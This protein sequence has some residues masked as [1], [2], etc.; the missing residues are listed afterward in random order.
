M[1]ELVFLAL[2]IILIALVFD[3]INGFHDSANSIATVVTTGVLAP[4]GAVTL[5]TLMN[6]VGVYLFGTAIASTVGKGIVN[7]GFVTLEV[8]LA[9]L[10]GAIAWNLLTWYKGIPSSSSHALIGGLIGA[11]VAAGGASALLWNGIWTVVAFILV[12]PLVGLA[13]SLAFGILVLQVVKNMQPHKINFWFRKLQL[14]SSSSYSL[15]HGTNDAQKTMG[16]IALV[17]FSQHAID[18]FYIPFWVIMAAYSAIA[19]GTLFGG[20]RIVKTMGTKIT[21]LKPIDG[22][23][24]ETASAL[25]LL[26]TAHAGI[27]VSTTHVIAGAILGVGTLKRGKHPRWNVARN[28]LA[29]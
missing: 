19:L 29:A 14:L 16:I 26:G 24:A 13:A 9:A 7:P 3:F 28:I 25:T 27:P 22:F 1:P 12:A 8:V 6:F 21:K 4:L 17:L 10:L 5:A 23:T 18:H 20:W 15:G 2:A 11:T